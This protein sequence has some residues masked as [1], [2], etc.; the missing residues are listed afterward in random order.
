MRILEYHVRTLCRKLIDHTG[1]CLLISRNRIRTENDRVIRL[2]R[3]FTVYIPCHSGKCSH[4]FS[5]ASCCDQNGLLRWIVLQLID[6][7][8]CILRN[9]QIPKLRCC[10]DDIYHA[11]SFYHNFSSVLIC[12]VDNLL[13]TVYVRCKCRDDDSCVL[14]LCKNM[15]KRNSHRTL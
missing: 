2:N 4:G 1:Y 5:L 6:L 14:M 13:H 3:H 12:R 8:Q 15:I 11:A 9:I 7:D 10:R